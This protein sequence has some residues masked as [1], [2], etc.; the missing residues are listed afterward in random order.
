MILLAK[1]NTDINFEITMD[2]RAIEWFTQAA[3]KQLQEAKKNAVHAMGIVWSDESKSITR[4]DDHIDTGL[5][6]NSIGYATGSPNS[7]LYEMSEETEKTELVI[8]ADISYASALEK[9]Y[10]IFARGLDLS[11]D[12]MEKV[13]AIQVK[14][15]LNL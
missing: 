14:R 5:Y 2:K 6:V 3:P 11:H 13:A 12:R 4:E 8:G 9:R 10:N 15:T 7:P 1:K